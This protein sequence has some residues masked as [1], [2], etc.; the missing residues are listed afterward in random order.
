MID[1]KMRKGGMATNI[2]IFLILFSFGLSVYN[3]TSPTNAYPGASCSFT[4]NY[5]HLL[6]AF[7][8]NLFDFS[9][10]S[11]LTVTGAAAIIGTL[12]FPN[13]Y[14]LF[15]GVSTLVIGLA[16][17]GGAI[18][19]ILSS[20]AGLPPPVMDLISGILVSTFIIAMIA[21]FA[22]RDVW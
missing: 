6:D 8:V 1:M 13:P 4:T 10:A 22:G 2:I 3:C 14:T 18:T 11:L 12:F 16:M 9:A 5:Q 15:L 7:T 17:P 19:A 20:Q 21:W